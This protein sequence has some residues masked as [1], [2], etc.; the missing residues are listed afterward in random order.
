MFDGSQTKTVTGTVVQLEWLNPHVF[1]WVYV[2]NPAR[3][4]GYDLYAFENGSRN[5]PPPR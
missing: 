1:H 5:A 4:T 3:E 2:P